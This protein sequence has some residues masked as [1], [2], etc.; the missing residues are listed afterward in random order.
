MHNPPDGVKVRSPNPCSSP[1]FPSPFSRGATSV[2]L[3]LCTYQGSTESNATNDE[4]EMK[5]RK[6]IETCLIPLCP[7]SLSLRLLT[8]SGRVYVCFPMLATRCAETHPVCVCGRECVDR[9]RV[10][11]LAD[12]STLSLSSATEEMPPLL[13]SNHGSP[14]SK[15]DHGNQKLCGGHWRGPNPLDHPPPTTPTPTLLLPLLC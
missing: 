12:S 7:S 3:C 10:C 2:S 13:P 4:E 6:G 9:A 5:G 15:C 11:V 1:L 8:F 14:A